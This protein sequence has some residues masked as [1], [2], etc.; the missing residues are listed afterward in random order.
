MSLFNHTFAFRKFSHSSNQRYLADKSHQLRTSQ[1]GRIPMPKAW[2]AATT[3]TGMGDHCSRNCGYEQAVLEAG[4]SLLLSSSFCLCVT[5]TG[6]V[7]LTIHDVTMNIPRGTIA[8]VAIIMLCISFLHFAL[9]FLMSWKLSAE[10][11]CLMS[12]YYGGMMIYPSRVLF[13]INWG[14]CPDVLVWFEVLVC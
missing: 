1:M 8:D 12:I 6:D 13:D 9:L 5:T 4:L 3:R 10:W 2:Q 11:G 7:F 14:G